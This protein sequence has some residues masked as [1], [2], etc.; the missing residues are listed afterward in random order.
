MNIF[1]KNAAIVAIAVM[2]SVSANAQQGEKAAGGHL[3]FGSGD[4]YSNIGFGAKFRYGVTDPIRLEGSFTFFL[5]K[6]YV[7]MWDLSANGHWLFQPNDQIVV[8]PLAGFSIMGIKFDWGDGDSSTDNGFGLNF[9]GGMDFKLN[10]KTALNFEL[11]YR[12]ATGDLDLD[13]LGISFGVVF[14]F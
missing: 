11:R 12:V 6:E 1:F 14:N 13:R 5:K 10:D 4:D 7:S 3:M 9:G 2:M 8:Y